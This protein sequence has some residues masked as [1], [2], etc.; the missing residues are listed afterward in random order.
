GLNMR[1][2]QPWEF[3]AGELMLTGGVDYDV[4]VDDRQGYENFLGAQLGA[5]GRLRRD[6]RDEIRSLAPYLQLAW[7]TGRLDIQAGMRHNEV[8]FEVD[9]RYVTPGNGDDSGR[10]TYRKATPSLGA[11]YTFGPKLNVYA[12]WSRG[13]ET[14]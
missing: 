2:I 7:Q 9:D 1:W 14:P 5:K 4:S 8:A 6:E 10:M 12:G 3:K 13:F 11:G